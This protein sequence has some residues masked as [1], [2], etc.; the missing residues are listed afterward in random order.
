MKNTAAQL[1]QDF[2]LVPYDTGG[3]SAETLRAEL[4]E[5]ILANEIDHGVTELACHPGCA[6]PALVSSYAVERELELRTLCDG[7]VRDFLDSCGIA[8]VSFEEVEGLPAS[9]G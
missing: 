9:Q 7:R 6:D 5:K 1:M 8:L 3:K 2:I 4:V